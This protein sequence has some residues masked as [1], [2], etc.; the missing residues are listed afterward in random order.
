MRGS[1]VVIKHSSGG[2]AEHLRLEIFVEIGVFLRNLMSDRQKTRIF[3]TLTSARM[4][5]FPTC[6]VGRLLGA[7]D[8]VIF[9][10]SFLEGLFTILKTCLVDS[11]MKGMVAPNKSLFF[12]NPSQS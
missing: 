5:E 10:S 9:V 2:S 12:G 11:R 8:Q 6:K 7:F 3:D 1:G 4:K